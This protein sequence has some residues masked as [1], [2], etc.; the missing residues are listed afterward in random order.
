[1]T[2]V[3]SDLELTED[4]MAV[5]CGHGSRTLLDYRLAWARTLLRS[6]GAIVNDAPGHWLITRAGMEVTRDDMQVVI[7]EHFDNLK[8]NSHKKQQASREA[9]R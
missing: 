2:A 9:A 7:K 4:Q 1:M 8:D 5:L 6:M 3:A